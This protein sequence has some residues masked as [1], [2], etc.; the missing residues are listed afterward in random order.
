M[1]NMK[2]SNQE[3][4][5]IKRRRKF[6]QA[7]LNLRAASIGDDQ[8]VNKAYKICLN[9]YFNMNSA[10]ADA[11]VQSPL[12]SYEQAFYRFVTACLNFAEAKK[13]LPNTS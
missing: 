12:A 1:E 7:V 3:A 6:H 9:A 8:N 11:G 13:F 5:Y 4:V 2:P 10:A